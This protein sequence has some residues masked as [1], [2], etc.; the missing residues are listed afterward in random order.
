MTNSENHYNEELKSFLWTT[1]AHT[2]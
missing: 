1:Y 2:T